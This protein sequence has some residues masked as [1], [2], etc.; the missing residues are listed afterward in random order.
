MRGSKSLLYQP[1]I[2]FL[3]TY[4]SQVGRIEVRVLDLCQKALICGAAALGEKKEGFLGPEE[5]L[6]YT[7]L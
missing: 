7:A 3:L 2:E 5:P 6:S 4:Y 1:I